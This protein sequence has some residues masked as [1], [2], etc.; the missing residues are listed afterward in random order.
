MEKTSA[1][2]VNHLD[3]KISNPIKNANNIPICFCIIRHE[4]LENKCTQPFILN[5]Y[6]KLLPHNALSFCVFRLHVTNHNHHDFIINQVVNMIGHDHP[7]LNTFYT[8]EH[9][10][11]ILQIVTQLHSLNQ[12]ESRRNSSD[13]HL[14]QINLLP[15]LLTKKIVVLNIVI[16]R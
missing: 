14:E 7:S 8:I 11:R 15:N 5:N 3:W 9:H 6:I 10:P 2:F 13:G 1:L 12:I 4:P 16:T